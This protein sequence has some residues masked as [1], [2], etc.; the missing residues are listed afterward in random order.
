MA[1]RGRDLRRA[2]DVS[3]LLGTTTCLRTP[4]QKTHEINTPYITLIRKNIFF[5]W[6]GGGFLSSL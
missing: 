3:S 1:D 6:G 5:V 4:R 2:G